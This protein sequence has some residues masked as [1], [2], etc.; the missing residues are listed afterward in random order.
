ME[1]PWEPK[2]AEELVPT[3]YPD[4]VKAAWKVYRDVGA[5]SANNQVAIGSFAFE[6]VCR[7]PHIRAIC[8]R[9]LMLRFLVL[10]VDHSP[11]EPEAKEL[12]KYRYDGE[13]DDRL[14]RVMSQIAIRWIPKGGLHGFPFDGEAF[15]KQLREAA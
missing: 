11:D 12:A 5:P 15:M 14:F 4:D 9:A 8:H 10:N 7:G 3:V 1:N 13:L 2:D 6:Q